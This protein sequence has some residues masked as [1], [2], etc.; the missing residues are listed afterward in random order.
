MIQ[1]KETEKEYL[2]YIPAFQKERA[3]QIPERYW[4]IDRKAWVYPRTK[5]M[6]DALLAE[7]A[8]DL[9]DI[10][11][12]PPDI[13]SSSVKKV[14]LEK[15]N[16]EL[17]EQLEKIGKT[18]EALLSTKSGEKK[19]SVLQAQIA[20][21]SATITEQSATINSLQT[22]FKTAQHKLRQSQ[23]ELE[24]LSHE[25]KDIQQQVN[26][27]NSETLEESIRNLAISSTGNNSTFELVLKQVEIDNTFPMEF[28]K[29]LERRLRDMLK[30]TEPEL[31]LFDLLSHA[32]DAELMEPEAFDLAH[33]IRKQRNTLVHGD[34]DAKTRKIRIVYLI[35]AAS[36]LWPHLKAP[37]S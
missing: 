12:T 35:T 17:Q 36:L 29:I 23:A 33:S 13:K 20:N 27:S 21:Q 22:D 10:Q 8:D 31:T 28:C 9:V 14:D 37:T 3:K 19:M 6:Y 34:I 4:D 26:S 7:F 30:T 16:A 24:Q 18:V 1:L 11:I 5:R 15:Q 32:K 2:L 25:I